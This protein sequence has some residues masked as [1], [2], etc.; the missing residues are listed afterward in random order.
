MSRTRQQAGAGE[1]Q[2][3]AE[4]TRGLTGFLTA[5][6]AAAVRKPRLTLVLLVALQTLPVIGQRDLWLGD[7]VRHGSALQHVVEDGHVMVL[8]LNGEPYPD[9]P[10]L[11]FW[12]AGAIAKVGGSTE[13]WVFFLAAAIAAAFFALA[14]LRLARD[15]AGLTGGAALAP[16]LAVTVLPLTALLS[17]STRMDLLFA[18][19]ITASAAALFRGLTRPG[20]ERSTLAAFAWAGAATWTKGPLGLA[21]PLVAAIGFLGWRGRLRR[22][23]GWDVLLGFA[24]YVVIMGAWA[25]GVVLAE[26]SDFFWSLLDG[27]VV[28]RFADAAHHRELFWFYAAV[29][30]PCVV[31]WSLLPF[32]LPWR[33]A[34]WL[35]RLRAAWAARRK[36][37]DGRAWLVAWSLGGFALLSVMSTK[38]FIYLAPL[39]PPLV[40]LSVQALSRA[41]EAVR[42][43][44]WTTT[45]GLGLG[46]ALGLP[47]VAAVPELWPLSAFDLVPAA[48]AL[49]AA[50]LLTFALRRA[51]VGPAVLGSALGLTLVTLVAASTVAPALDDFA[52]PRG[53]AERVREHRALGYV[54][55][56]YGL[57]GG[58]IAYHAHGPMFETRDP[59]ALALFLA[60]HPRALV[61]LPARRWTLVHGRVPTL[62]LAYEQRFLDETF[63]V[64]LQDLVPTRSGGR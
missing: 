43:R 16:A 44:F 3:A 47:F 41:P 34:G 11:W 14:T 54:P 29:I 10:P 18:A 40:V 57:Y 35:A 5:V 17:R 55:A 59:E 24:L 46:L 4:P 48:V 13:P 62:R 9:K 60:G 12:L 32:T 45:A 7:E 58:Q 22:L 30:A 51:P 63:Y 2:H 38:F 64:A 25:A 37:D 19:F 39:V 49:F 1:E 56:V 52:S 8:Y 42:A 31:P 6:W 15:V 28:R 61:V 23:L 27:Q 21:L 33:P 26:G 50:S 20:A 53:T 36:G